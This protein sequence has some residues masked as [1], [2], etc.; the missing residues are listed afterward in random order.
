MTS[1]VVY[2]IFLAVLL[3][4]DYHGKLSGTSQWIGNARTK[5]RTSTN[6]GRRS[7]CAFWI[8]NLP[9]PVGGFLCGV[10]SFF[11]AAVATRCRRMGHRWRTAAVV[12]VAEARSADA[13][14][15]ARPRAFRRARC[16]PPSVAGED[17]TRRYSEPAPRLLSVFP[18]SFFLVCR[19]IRVRWIGP[20]IR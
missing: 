8:F 3:P 18:P 1:F 15:R 13:A 11:V 14:P 4:R 10:A 2:P 19:L 5:K 9:A 17:P 7:F 16:G 20:P 6:T 12:G